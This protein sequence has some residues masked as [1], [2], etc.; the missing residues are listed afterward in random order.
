[1]KVSGSVDLSRL[2]DHDNPQDVYAWWAKLAAETYPGRDFDRVAGAFVLTDR[3]YAGLFPGYAP[4]RT[5]YHDFRHTLDVFVAAARLVDGAA[6]AGRAL[7]ADLAEEIL[8]AALLHD[9]GYLQKAEETRGTGAKY[10]AAHVGRSIEFTLRHAA[11]FGLDSARAERIGRIIMATDLALD[12]GRSGSG[13]PPGSGDPELE[14]ARSILA[15]ADLLGQMADRAYLEKLLFLY[16]EF[17]EAGFGDYDTAF[18]VLA[19]TAGFYRTVKQR[20]DTTLDAVSHLAHLH[21]AVRAQDDRDLYRESIER[22]MSYLDSILQDHSVNF[23][24][25]LRRLDLEEAESRERDRLA[26]LGVRV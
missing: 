17:K 14:R 2:L 26:S 3:L 6:L 10:T 25:R 13:D 18:D 8:I 15:A 7:S 1:M 12:W 11:A 16:Y 9:S 20:L 21:F 4:C 22:Q 19:K 5:G 24:K 23:R